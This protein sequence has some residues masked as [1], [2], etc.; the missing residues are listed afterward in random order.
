MVHGMKKG[1]R[2]EEIVDRWPFRKGVEGPWATS[3]T[4]FGLE[5][6]LAD[7]DRSGK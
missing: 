4:V 6:S 3:H 5:V 1:A 7:G 2:W